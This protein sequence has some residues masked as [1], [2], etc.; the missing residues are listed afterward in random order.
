MYGV[1]LLVQ[2]IGALGC[3]RASLDVKRYKCFL[4]LVSHGEA[5]GFHI[6][7]RERVVASLCTICDHGGG[8][9]GSSI[10]PKV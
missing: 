6:F 7:G 4:A 3:G 9:K 10:F 8:L 2:Y 5:T 1:L